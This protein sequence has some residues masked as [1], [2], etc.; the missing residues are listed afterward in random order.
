MEQKKPRPKPNYK[1]YRAN[2][3]AVIMDENYPNE[4][5]VWI[6]LRND[7]KDVWQFPQGGMDR[8]E[9]VDEAFFR[10][11]G[12]EIGTSNVEIIAR[13]PD[14]IKYDFPKGLSGRYS[15]Q[16]QKYLLAK[17]KN[18]KDINIHTQKPEFS[19]FKFIPMA[20][21]FE[22]ITAFKVPAYTIAINYFKEN[23]Y[24]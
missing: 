2:V 12:E 23:G 22:H 18:N 17:L 13:H 20:D 16:K 8:N 4:K 5:N 19:D 10:E 15:G 9:S 1:I 24:L 21:L 7:M 11:L 14:W 6:G 3:A